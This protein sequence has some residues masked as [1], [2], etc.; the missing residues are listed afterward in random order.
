MGSTQQTS[1]I[2]SKH[3]SEIHIY[4][5]IDNYARLTLSQ[6]LNTSVKL[7]YSQ[8]S[9]VKHH[10]CTHTRMHARTHTHTHTHTLLLHIRM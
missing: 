4:N 9:V 8:R 6:K 1:K 3:N 7:A 5:D 2:D 10:R